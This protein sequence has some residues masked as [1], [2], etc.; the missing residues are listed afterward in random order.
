MGVIEDATPDATVNCFRT[1]TSDTYQTTGAM[2]DTPNDRVITPNQVKTI[3]NEYDNVN[4]TTQSVNG[5]INK[6]PAT[7][8][9]AARE[10]HR[11]RIPF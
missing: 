6:I 3:I 7:S 10:M 1:V 4:E 9:Q 11:D 8:H 2:N 5:S